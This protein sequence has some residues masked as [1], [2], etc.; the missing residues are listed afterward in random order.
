MS[1]FARPIASRK[2][3]GVRVLGGTGVLC[4]NAAA[5]IEDSGKGTNLQRWMSMAGLG[6][7]RQ[8]QGSNRTGN[9]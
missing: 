8:G 9:S 6:S 4:E 7:V 3:F 1:P 5:F 2:V